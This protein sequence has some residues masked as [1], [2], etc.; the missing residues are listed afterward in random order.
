MDERD[1]V[2]L[3]TTQ[4]VIAD[5]P[6]RVGAPANEG[7]RLVARAALPPQREL[8]QALAHLGRHLVEAPEPLPSPDAD[9][10]AGRDVGAS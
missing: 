2:G 5:Q 8:T 1:E 3:A 9:A 6:L 4:A 10:G 7:D